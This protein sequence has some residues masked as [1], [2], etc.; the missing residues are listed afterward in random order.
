MTA[1][2]VRGT[3]RDDAVVRP[4]YLGDPEV[5]GRLAHEAAE[6]LGGAGRRRRDVASRRLFGLLREAGALRTDAL[7][8]EEQESTPAARRSDG[9]PV[10]RELAS[11]ASLP[12]ADR[13]AALIAHSVARG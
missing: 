11:P 10:R 3:S 4:L 12:T 9:V 2:A 1:S 13:R 6:T 5:L 8:L 7:A